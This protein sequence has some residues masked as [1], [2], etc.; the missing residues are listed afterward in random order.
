MRPRAPLSDLYVMD[1]H[2]QVRPATSFKE[3]RRAFLK[4]NRTILRNNFQDDPKRFVHTFFTGINLNP[5]GPPLVF[6]TVVMGATARR[7]YYATFVE[8]VQ[9]HAMALTY[10]A[11]IM[12]GMSVSALLVGLDGGKSREK[13]PARA[14]ARSAPDLEQLSN[15]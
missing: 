5:D 10:I 12:G 4:T 1:E 13:K 7:H 3:W 2:N 15:E 6:Q 14:S 9:G 11:R 8:A